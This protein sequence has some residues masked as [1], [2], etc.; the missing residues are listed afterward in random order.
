MLA[1]LPDF[2][3]T[4]RNEAE[5]RL[6]SHEVLRFVT[7]PAVVIVSDGIREILPWGTEVEMLEYL[8]PE[9]RDGLAAAQKRAMRRKS[10]LRVQV[11]TSVYPVLRFWHDGLALDAKVAPHLRGLVDVYDGATHIFQC[12]IIASGQENDELVCTFKR[13]TA[14]HDRPALDYWRDENAPVAFLTKS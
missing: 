12:L 2:P 4:R 5:L 7:N 1:T 3:G 8:P 9:V 6:L 14:V 11:G 13:S 10:R